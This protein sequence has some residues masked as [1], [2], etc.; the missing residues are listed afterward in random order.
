MKFLAGILGAL[1][2]LIAIFPHSDFCELNR[3]P[4]IYNHFL[5]HKEA[6]GDSFLEFIYEDFL[7]DRGDRDGHHNNKPKEDFPFQSHS[8]HTHCCAY[9][10]PCY[11]INISLP[12]I[13][14]MAITNYYS[15]NYSFLY[16]DGTP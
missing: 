4:T 9:T 15:F 5:E 10:L 7:S 11:D 14:L 2:T 8:F 13:D 1:F 3:I 6:D 16:L 12:T